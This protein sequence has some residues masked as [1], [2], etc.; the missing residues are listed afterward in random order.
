HLARVD[1]YS[2]LHKCADAR[3]YIISISLHC[4]LHSQRGIACAHRVVLVGDGGAEEGHNTVPANLVDRTFVM[5]NRLHH[6]HDDR[7]EDL[8]GLL[9]IAVRE[10]LHGTL[11]VGEKNRD[12]LALTLERALRGEN[13]FREVLGCVAIRRGEPRCSKSSS[14]GLSALEAKLRARRQ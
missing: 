3:S 4:V 2:D 5:V 13:P 11:E 8:A 6:S 12:L 14:D 7:V 1:S 9:K 10:Q